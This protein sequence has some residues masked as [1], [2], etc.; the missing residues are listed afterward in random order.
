MEV[1]IYLFGYIILFCI[2]IA[3]TKRIK[4]RKKKYIVTAIIF[5]VIH[6]TLFFDHFLEIFVTPIY[7]KLHN[8]EPITVY[9]TPQEWRETST[10]DIIINKISDNKSVIAP[11]NYNFNYNDSMSFN[12]EKYELFAVS[13]IDPRYA[14]YSSENKREIFNKIEMVYYDVKKDVLIIGKSRYLV[15]Y[16]SFLSP[17][18][19]IEEC[20]NSGFDDLDKALSNYQ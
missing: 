12:N 10:K 18:N 8:N 16:K 11:Y 20:E 6:F 17:H 9:T 5:L 13:M 3:Y 14:L 1:I 15:Y 4:H 19:Y 2:I 7:C